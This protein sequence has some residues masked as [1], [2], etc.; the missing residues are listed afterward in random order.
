MLFGTVYLLAHGIVKVALV[1]APL[2]NRIWAYPWMIAVLLAFI[3]YQLYRIV[4]NP[5]AGLIAVTVFDLAIVTLTWR[6]YGR[7]RELLAQA[8]V[9]VRR[10]TGC[11]SP[12][13]CGRPP[14]ARTR[15]RQL[16]R[17]VALRYPAEPV[18]RP[19]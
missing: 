9:N 17:T 18:R 1:I 6:E 14:S 11:E 13:G 15:D 19:G 12:T 8:D 2:A 3:G 16:R 10:G 4:L 7:Q 5:T